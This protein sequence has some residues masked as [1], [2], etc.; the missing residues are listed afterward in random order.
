MNENSNTNHEKTTTQAPA[1]R[2]HPALLNFIAGTFGG[3]GGVLA[4]HPFDTIKVRL[5]NQTSDNMKYKGTIHCMRTIVKEE[6]VFGLFKGITSP[7]VS[8]CVSSH[9]N[10]TIHHITFD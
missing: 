2:I 3:I 6:T 10:S 4:G 9:S 5:Q 7:M 8:H 1:F